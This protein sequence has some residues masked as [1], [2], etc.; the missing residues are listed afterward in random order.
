MEEW[1]K[2][3]IKASEDFIGTAK[4]LPNEKYPTIGYGTYHKYPDGSLIQ[5]GDTITEEEAEK[6]MIQYIKN[7]MPEIYK[8][9]PKFDQLPSQMKGAIIDMAYRGGGVSFGKSPAFVKAINTGIEDVQF[10]DKELAEIVRQT[11]ISKTS[12]NLNDRKQ[13]RAAMIYGVYNNDHNSSIRSLGGKNNKITSTEYT[14]FDQLVNT[15]GSMW[16]TIYRSTKSPANFVQRL[17]EPKKDYVKDWEHEG[18]TSTHKLGYVGEDGY[19]VVYPQVQ[20]IDYPWYRFDKPND[21]L[22]DFSDPKYEMDWKDIYKQAVENGD[23]LH[24]PKGTGE[25]FTTQYKKYY[26]GFKKDGGV[27][28]YL[29]LF[30][31]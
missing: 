25:L 22:H 19:E 10:S 28:N 11:D 8:Y 24:V 31:K 20:Y 6:M 9:F 27:I 16:N 17:W 3:F 30:K 4:I 5:V 12:G 13:R 15:P 14:N 7:I 21:G 26:P 2:N 23:T 29:N 18:K 1:L